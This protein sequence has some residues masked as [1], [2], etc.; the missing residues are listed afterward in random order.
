VIEVLAAIGGG[1]T[2]VLIALDA[3]LTYR[4]VAAMREQIAARDRLEKLDEEYD[5]LET[6]RNGL[7]VEL[8]SERAKTKTLTDRV[9][10]VEAERNEAQRQEREYVVERIKRAGVADAN[11]IIADLLVAPLA[12]S[13]P[14]AVPR[15]S[16]PTSGDGLMDPSEV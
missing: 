8:D 12:G 13:V 14:Q 6:D 15:S 7:K 3:W 9:A 2:L 10:V 11:G 1:A 4:L 5:A 16:Q